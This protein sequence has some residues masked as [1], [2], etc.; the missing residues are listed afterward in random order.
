MPTLVLVCLFAALL[1]GLSAMF[2]PD[3]ATYSGALWFYIVFL[4]LMTALLMLGGQFLRLHDQR[5]PVL[6]HPPFL[7][8]IWCVA[9]IG[10]PG[11]ASFFNPVLIDSIDDLVG[12]NYPYA[13][14]ALLLVTT[15]L[16]S[17]WL[18]YGSGL[19][20]F[21]PSIHSSR[22]FADLIIVTPHIVLVFYFLVVLVRLVRISVVGISYAADPGA[23]GT[24]SAFHQWIGYL[25]SGAY[26]VVSLVALRVFQRKWPFGLLILVGVVE[27]IFAI[28]SGTMKPA[29]WLIVLL[30]LS[31]LFCG[32]NLLRYIPY[33]LISLYVGI[34]IVP[35]TEYLRQNIN[36]L[37]V[38]SPSSMVQSSLKAFRE[39]WG[40]GVDVGWNMFSE[41]VMGRQA[42]ISQ[43]IGVI[44][45]KTPSE[46]PYEG[47]HQFLAI[48]AYVVPRALW[49]DKP[50]ITEG[51]SFSIAY[52]NHPSSTKTSSVRTI[53]GQAYI[54]SGWP[55]VVLAC[56]VLGFALALFVRKLA[57]SGLAPVYLALIP[58]LIDIENS[59][60]SLVIQTAQRVVVL[61]VICVFVVW[62]AKTLNVGNG[63]R[64]YF[65]K[66]F[67]DKVF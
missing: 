51:V 23:W 65:V 44:L 60:V 30:A 36:D 17:I 63:R 49:P 46:L 14:W 67:E 50:V 22:F 18:G 15:G 38:N 35:V 34:A 41:K 37:N 64:K 62:I 5:M 59:Y 13:A 9:L 6:A 52:L 47:F 32:Y 33:I 58:D 8:T 7:M 2:D 43:N 21:R 24:F 25:E 4:G 48:P 55:G 27:L 10:I 3:T 54:F 42:E 20:L 66:R 26:V 31:A 40:Q 19:L 12:I 61:L 16:A 11:L 29:F 1:V 56:I 39:T 53:F 28:I 45:R 57:Y